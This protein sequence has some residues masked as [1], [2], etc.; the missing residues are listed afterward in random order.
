MKIAMFDAEQVRPLCDDCS[1]DFGNEVVKNEQDAAK[2][3]TV[4]MDI[5]PI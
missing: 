4:N 5:A 3:D 1:S 2:A